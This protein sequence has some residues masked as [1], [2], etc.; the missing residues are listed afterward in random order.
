MQAPDFPWQEMHNQYPHVEQWLRQ[1]VRLKHKYIIA[2]THRYLKMSL[3]RHGETT[4][5]ITPSDEAKI[6]GIGSSDRRSDGRRASR[7]G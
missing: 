2:A 7:M 3:L 4:V 5:L 1:H 6:V